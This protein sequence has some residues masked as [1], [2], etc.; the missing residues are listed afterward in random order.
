MQFIANSAN[1]YF[2][3]NLISNIT[4]P[5]ILDDISEVKC[6]VAY[7]NDMRELFDICYQYK[8]PLTFY[9]RNDYQIPVSP[10][11]LQWFIGKQ[12][13]NIICKLVGRFFHAKTIWIVGYGVYIG[14][15]NLTQRAWYNNI[16]AGIFLSEYE[17]ENYQMREQLE[18]F[19]EYLDDS[20]NY[21]LLSQEIINQLKDREERYQKIR[22]LIVEFENNEKLSNIPPVGDNP[23]AV[24]KQIAQEKSKN[25][26][27]KEWNSTLEFL[28]EIAA[29]ISIAYRPIWVS[30][31]IPKTTQ[32][33]QFL[34]AYYYQYVVQNKKSMHRELNS[35]NKNNRAKALANAMDWWK[36]TL[37]PPSKEDKQ[38]YD[39]GPS[40]LELAIKCKTSLLNRS[41]FIDLCCKIHAFR[42]HSRQIKYE[43]L[44][45][46][47]ESVADEEEKIRKGAEWV[48]DHKSKHGKTVIE[49]IN[50]VLYSGKEQDLVLRLWE[51]H[52]SEVW[53]IPHFG[54]SCLG[55]LV[56]WALPNKYPPRNNRT[57]KALY[58]LGYSE[59][60]VFND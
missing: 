60:K 42:N 34:H 45:I 50:Y 31:T 32:A 51:A 44:G 14:S 29:D 47:A 48:Y 2:H 23:L 16:E 26:F 27:I 15:A 46:S 5:S 11:M 10:H 57:N 54:L 21:I 20:K 25:Q 55:E 41:E 58:A 28:R 33:D 53:K 18:L 56:G 19:F 1:N 40:I 7:G 12:K 35:I 17:I 37:S 49:L 13:N 6:A 52:R 39:W 22:N 24:D 59:V 8:I 3:K 4:N 30:E 38:F 43:T 36:N 9:C